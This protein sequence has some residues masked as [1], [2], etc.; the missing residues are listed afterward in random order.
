MGSNDD[1][2]SVQEVHAEKVAKVKGLMR[3]EDVFLLAEIFKAMGDS[4][5]IRI[6]HALALEELCVCDLAALLGISPSALSHQLRHLR[7]LR[8]VKPRKAGKMVF[9]SLD[10]D[11]IL[12]LF[13]EGLA[14]IRHR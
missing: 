12:N 11:H 14:H 4:T 9:Y 7:N 6:L 1:T 3:E 10:D 2:C 5:R 13:A 8:L